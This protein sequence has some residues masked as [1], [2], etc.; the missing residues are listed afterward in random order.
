M[1]LELLGLT[2]EQ[3][4]KGEKWDP[5]EGDTRDTGDKIGDQVVNLDWLNYASEVERLAKQNHVT[6]LHSR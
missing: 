6:N 5:H 1:L 2:P 4:A 3:I